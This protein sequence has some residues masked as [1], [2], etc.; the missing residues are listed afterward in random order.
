MFFEKVEDLLSAF[1]TDINT[2]YKVFQKEVLQG[3]TIVSDRFTFE[4]EITAKLIRKGHLIVEVPID[5]V[6][7][8]NTQGKKI[9]WDTALQMYWGIIKYRNIKI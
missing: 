9:R 4:T 7:R 1:L 3:I 8:S 5:Y 2:C 6:A